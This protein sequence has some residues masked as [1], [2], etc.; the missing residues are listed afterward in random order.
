MG[1]D[2]GVGEHRAHLLVAAQRVCLHPGAVLGGD[3]AGPQRL[4]QWVLRRRTGE[5]RHEFG[6]VARVEAGLEVALG[7]HEV[8]LAEA[9]GFVVEVRMA[10]RR[11]R[12]A[13]PR[14]EAASYMRA[15]AGGLE[16]SIVGQ[17]LDRERIHVVRYE[18][19]PVATGAGFD[20]VP[21]A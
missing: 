6:G 16:S 13:T 1:R 11:R 2:R 3:Q 14:C 12:R 15:A 5:I 4:A 17:L 9:G 21:V 8:Q 7:D 18:R 19:Q 10:P 20:Q